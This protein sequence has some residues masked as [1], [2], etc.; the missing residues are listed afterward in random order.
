MS[1]DTMILEL[2]IKNINLKTTTTTTT[3]NYNPYHAAAAQAELK[4]LH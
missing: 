1:Y 4:G 2:G 3:N